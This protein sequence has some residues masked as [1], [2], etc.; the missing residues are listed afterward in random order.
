MKKCTDTMP[1]PE[2]LYHYT[3]IKSLAC[4]L[5]SRKLR[6]N[7]LNN[8]DDLEEG[9]TRD[10]SLLSSYTYVSSWTDNP[11]ESIPLWNMYSDQFNGVRIKLKSNPFKLNDI[12]FHKKIT[13]EYGKPPVYEYS[14]ECFKAFFTQKDWDSFDYMYWNIDLDDISK[15][16]IL[17]SVLE[18]VVYTSDEDKLYPYFFKSFKTEDEAFVN[19][20]NQLLIN[21]SHKGSLNKEDIRV[22]THSV[23]QY[24]SDAWK[25]QD[26]WRYIIRLYPLLNSQFNNP[27][28]SRFNLKYS[29]WIPFEYYDLSFDDNCF[30]EMEIM[31]GPKITFGE[32]IIVKNLV[33]TFNP[34]AKIVKSAL[35]GKIR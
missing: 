17:N 18:K 31:L 28:L 32:E 11:T 3:S 1:I 2:Y 23:G 7:N 13:Q 4:I 8:M 35:T 24:K 14:N 26:E 12:F 15:N 29:S 21:T 10:Y 30:S 19:N 5:S 20:E 25:F 22:F 33:Q 6:L 9:K 34:S 16:D 27:I